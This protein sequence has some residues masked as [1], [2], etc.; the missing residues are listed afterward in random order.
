MEMLPMIDELLKLRFINKKLVRQDTF[1][2][3][4]QQILENKMREQQ[5]IFEQKL[6]QQMLQIQ[7]QQ[8]KHQKLEAHV[9]KMTEKM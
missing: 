7:Q 8:Q 2:Q 4:L 9:K 3:Q 1:D 6:Q 5:L